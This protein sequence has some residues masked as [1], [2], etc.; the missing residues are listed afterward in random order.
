MKITFNFPFSIFNFQLFGQQ[1]VADVDV[2]GVCPQALQVIEG[3]CLVGED[4]D[5]HGTEV[6]QLP[7]VAA[8]ALTAQQLLAQILQGVLGVVERVL[9]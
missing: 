6:Q 9:T 8:V 4:V 5:D 1:D 3:S 2:L 7:G